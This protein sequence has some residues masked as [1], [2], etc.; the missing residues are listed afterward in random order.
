MAFSAGIK[1]QLH[2]R[3]P[4][5][6][7]CQGWLENKVN[8]EMGS[9]SWMGAGRVSAVGMDFCDAGECA[10]SHMKGKQSPVLAEGEKGTQRQKLI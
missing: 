4:L 10:L 8:G 7:L 2:H 5:I 1:K 3:K 6:Y 9:G